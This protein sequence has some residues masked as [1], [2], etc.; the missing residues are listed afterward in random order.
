MA[1]FK[2]ELVSPERMLASANVAMVVVPGAEGDFGVLPGHA[3]LM[4]TIRPGIIEVYA[5]EGS[6]PSA[7]YEIEGGFAEV[8]PEG[9]TIL[10]EAVTAI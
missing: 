10:A 9:L 5:T 7:R 1:T 6:S 4:S 8:T 2:F 3:P